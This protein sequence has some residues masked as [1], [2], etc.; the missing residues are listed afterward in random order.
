LPS[1]AS[2]DFSPDVLNL[3]GWAVAEPVAELPEA[4][5]QFCLGIGRCIGLRHFGV[6]LRG[7]GLSADP[8]AACVI[9]V[10]ASPLLVQLYE[11]GHRRAALEAQ[12]K[13]LSA[14]FRNRDHEH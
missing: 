9:E 14:V 10:N 5:K 12:C 13:V 6:D 11:L 8:T 7:A 4:W 1:G 3:N 2:L